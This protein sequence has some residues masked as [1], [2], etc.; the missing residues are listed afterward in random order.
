M[1]EFP[2]QEEFNFEEQ[3]EIFSSR[4]KLIQEKFTKEWLGEKR[5]KGSEA[6]AQRHIQAVQSCEGEI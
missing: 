5:R 4:L 6:A 3:Y 2:A 1:A